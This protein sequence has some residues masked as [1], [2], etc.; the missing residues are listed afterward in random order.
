VVNLVSD[1]EILAL[2]IIGVSQLQMSLKQKLSVSA[3]FATGVL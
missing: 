2:P 1:M 3:V